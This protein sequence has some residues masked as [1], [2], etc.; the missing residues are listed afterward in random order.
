[1]PR[2]RQQAT[3]ALH[4]KKIRIPA[5]AQKK[6]QPFLQPVH[7]LHYKQLVASAKQFIA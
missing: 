3:L 1:V 6:T 7:P 5:I 2:V 4:E